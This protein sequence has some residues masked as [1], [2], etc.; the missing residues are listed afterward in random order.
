MVERPDPPNP[1]GG[2]DAST[3]FVAWAGFLS[4]LILAAIL[5]ALAAQH[6]RWIP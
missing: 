5:F 3:K 6:V 1:E 4:A 2:D